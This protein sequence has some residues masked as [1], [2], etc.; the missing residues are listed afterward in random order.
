MKVWVKVEKKKKMLSLKL[1]FD[2]SNEKS[3]RYKREY[4]KSI[5]WKRCFEKKD[6][7]LFLYIAFD[8][9]LKRTLSLDLF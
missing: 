9:F 1:S 5:K 3:I 8:R 2:P 7:P 4:K 6:Q